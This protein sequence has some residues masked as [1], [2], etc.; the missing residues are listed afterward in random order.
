MAQLAEVGVREL[1]SEL[2][3]LTSE[4]REEGDYTFSFET[5][6]GGG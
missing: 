6:G 4:F 1:L 5:G 2:E 3:D